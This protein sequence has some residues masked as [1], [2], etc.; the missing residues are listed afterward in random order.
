MLV[1]THHKS[2][3]RAKDQRILRSMK[4]KYCPFLT[5]GVLDV[6]N[7][8]KRVEIFSK[9]INT[10]NIIRSVACYWKKVNASTLKKRIKNKISGFLPWCLKIHLERSMTRTSQYFIHRTRM[11]LFVC[12]LEIYHLSN[13]SRH[14]ISVAMMVWNGECLLLVILNYLLKW[15][16]YQRRRVASSFTWSMPS[17]LL[18][19]SIPKGSSL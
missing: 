13:N 1:T 9:R 3:I 8:S 10:R 16:L 2:I 11:K 15:W 17:W 18:L 5:K 14:V 6:V 4:L 7:S 19:L 12:E